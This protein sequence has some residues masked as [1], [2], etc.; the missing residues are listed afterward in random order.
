MMMSGS[1]TSFNINKYMNY[2][3]EEKN[4]EVETNHSNHSIAEEI[5]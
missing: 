1:W 2:K 5:E 4:I 3:N